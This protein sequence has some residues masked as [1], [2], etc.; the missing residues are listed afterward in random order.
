MKRIRFVVIVFV[1]IGVFAWATGVN[2][3]TFEGNS[4]GVFINP[5]GPSGMVVSG[6]GT[7]DFY[8]GSAYPT[9]G[10][11]R[12]T[13]AGTIST[14]ADTPFSFGNLYYYNGPILA[15][16][17]ADSVDLSVTVSL[18]SPLS[19]GTSFAFPFQLIN[20]VNT[21][22]PNAS[23]DYLNFVATPSP[24][25]FSYGGVDYTLQLLGF[26]DITGSGFSGINQFHVLEN[27]YATADLFGMFTSVANVRP[28][29]EPSTLLLLG[30][31]LAGLVGCGS[32]RF[33]K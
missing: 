25:Y 1:L 27:S 7:N 11:M 20:T 9:S 18:T 10:N 28:V 16:T 19:T 33:K 15:G 5:I 12:F 2:A 26:G 29:P 14:E 3:A 4:S 32:R 13:G 17:H 31:G 8:W 21:S 6:V 24:A 22:D 23:A 30:I